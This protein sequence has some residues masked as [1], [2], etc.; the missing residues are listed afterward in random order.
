MPADRTRIEAN[1]LEMV[2][3]MDVP[4]KTPIPRVTKGSPGGA[5]ARCAQGHPGGGPGPPTATAEDAAVGS[6]AAAAPPTGPMAQVPPGQQRPSAARFPNLSNLPTQIADEGAPPDLAR[7]AMSSAIDPNHG[8][9]Q[10]QPAN[11]AQGPHAGNLPMDY[12][13]MNPS[14][15]SRC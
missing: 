2:Q 15:A 3:A 11:G 6:V 12:P 7:T 5:A 1:P 8:G 4:S 9:E 10:Q 14:S 13:V